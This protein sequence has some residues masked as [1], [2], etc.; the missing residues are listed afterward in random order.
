MRLWRL[1]KATRPHDSLE[2]EAEG[3]KRVGGRWN[4]RGTPIIHASYNIATAAL[5]ILV[6]IDWFT[7]PEHVLLAIDVPDD[8]SIER[9]EIADLPEDWDR[10]PAPGI[11]SSIGDDWVKERTSL[12]LEVPSVASPYE[13]NV[14]INPVHSA[15]ARCKLSIEGP[16]VF[17]GRLKP[18]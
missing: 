9:I 7:A 5:E 4:S 6:H 12:L 15:I 2:D 1:A 3:A 14:L 16:Y 17:D 18:A 13:R 11:L 8:A 10:Y